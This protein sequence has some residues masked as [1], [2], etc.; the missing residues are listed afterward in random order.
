MY[1]ISVVAAE[2]VIAMPAYAETQTAVAAIAANNFLIFIIKTPYLR[3]ALPK[4]PHFI[5]Y[6]IILSQFAHKV[7]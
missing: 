7:K 2:D 4:I 6:N 5:V 3:T 1:A